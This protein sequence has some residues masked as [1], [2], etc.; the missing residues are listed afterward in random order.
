M[1]LILII[2]IGQMC[3]KRNKLNCTPFEY[4]IPISSFKFED[5]NKKLDSFIGW[6]DLNPKP[7]SEPTRAGF[8]DRIRIS[9]SIRIESKKK[10]EGEEREREEE[11]TSS[12][13][14][15]QVL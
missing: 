13:F 6:M 12:R 9:D 7:I 1:F 5:D 11:E 14:S 10:H 4:N 2:D 3:A 8:E 15:A